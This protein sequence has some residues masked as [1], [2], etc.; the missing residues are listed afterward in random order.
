MPGNGLAL[1]VKVCRQVELV[2]L[3]GR[4][5]QLRDD[6][7]LAR[8]DVVGRL[9]VV[10]DIDIQTLRGQIADVAHRGLDLVIRAQVLI[11]RLGLGGRL[12][13]DQRFLRIRFCHL[14]VLVQTLL[15]YWRQ[16]NKVR[17]VRR[18]WAVP[19]ASQ[20]RLGNPFRS[21]RLFGL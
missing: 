16:R 21:Y 12:D 8:H 10:L 2:A 6:A 7:L 17:V 19:G 20:S 4:R 11:D 9:E 18:A 15:Q 1:A 5:L 3:F 13:D 14:S